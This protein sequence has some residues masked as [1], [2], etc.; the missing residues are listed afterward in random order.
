MSIATET[1]RIIQ[2][3]SD[4]KTS[5]EK[6]GANIYTESRIDTFASILDTEPLPFV[7]AI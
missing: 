5:I 3:K 2:A 7:P 1:Q 6:R 4:L